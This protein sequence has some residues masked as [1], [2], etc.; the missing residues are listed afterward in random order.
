MGCVAFVCLQRERGRAQPRMKLGWRKG[1]EAAPSRPSLSAAGRGGR[2]AQG[3]DKG[4]LTSRLALASPCVQGVGEG[5]GF[6]VQVAHGLNM[7]EQTCDLVR[8]L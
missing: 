3:P 5:V 1:V 2:Q 8:V 4:Q 7:N 6:S